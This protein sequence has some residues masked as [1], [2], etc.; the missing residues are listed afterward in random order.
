ML[1]R[2]IEFAISLKDVSKVVVSTDSLYYQK[3]AIK[4]GADC[5]F[6]RPKNLANDLSHDIDVFYHCLNWL[7]KIKIIFLI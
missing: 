5:P 3:L 1:Q 6:L 7:K 4:Y 2:S